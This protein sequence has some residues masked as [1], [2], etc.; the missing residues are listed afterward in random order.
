MFK[1][2][3]ILM[4]KKKVKELKYLTPKQMFQRLPIALAK[5]KAGNT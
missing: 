4:N 5:L 3:L 2:S 1:K